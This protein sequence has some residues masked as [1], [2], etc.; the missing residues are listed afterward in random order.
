V[1]TVITAA[2]LPACHQNAI[3]PIITVIEARGN[4][5]RYGREKLIGNYHP[6]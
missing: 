6:H 3:L 5:V 1:I 2:V 4:V